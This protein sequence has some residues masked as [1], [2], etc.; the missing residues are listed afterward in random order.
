MFFLLRTATSNPF[1]FNA[2]TAVVPLVR[3]AKSAVAAKLTY[4]DT[5]LAVAAGGLAGGVDSVKPLS[6]LYLAGLELLDVSEPASRLKEARRVRDGT[7]VTP[8]AARGMGGLLG[9]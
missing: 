8:T 3:V 1:L 7:R 2:P 9:T 6:R 4:A 5:N